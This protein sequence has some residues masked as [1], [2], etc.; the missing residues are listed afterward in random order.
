MS[1]KERK[2]KPDEAAKPLGWKPPDPQNPSPTGPGNPPQPAT[3]PVKDD[4]T[5]EQ[6][7]DYRK[8]QGR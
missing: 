3:E 6:V 8:E 7:E 4:V 1:H 5:D 2:P